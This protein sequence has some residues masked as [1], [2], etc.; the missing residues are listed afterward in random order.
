[1]ANKNTLSKWIHRI[2]DPAY[3][4]VGIE[5]NSDCIR[6]A[7]ISAHG[8]KIRVEHLDSVPLPSGAVQI[9]PFKPNIVEPETVAQA[10]K[11]LWMRVRQRPPKICLLLQDRSALAFS[12][13]LEAPPENRNECIELLRFKLKKSIPFRTEEAHIG[14]FQD[15]GVADFRSSN[16]WVTVIHSHVLQQYEEVI[17]SAIGSDSGLVDLCTFNLMNLA[18]DEIQNQKWQQEDHLYINLN[19]DYISLAI[20]QR[21]RLVFYRSREMEHH[22]GMIEEAMEEIHP[23]VMFYQDKLAGTN[24]SR[25]FLYAF[26]GAEELSRTLEQTHSLKSVLLN[27]GAGSHRDSRVFAPLLG[28]LMSRKPEF[29]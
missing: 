27:P 18:N 22:N 9:N 11:D 7:S 12:V 2:T 21:D 24:F 20:T 25:A 17:R 5:V 28:L 3:P 6:L 16:L 10:L 13:T 29:L 19:R 26:E 4:N 15:S 1:M 14:Y 8:G 23:A